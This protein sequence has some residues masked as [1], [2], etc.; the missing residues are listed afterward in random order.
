MKEK[1]NRSNKLKDFKSKFGI[2]CINSNV[3][4]LKLLKNIRSI[5]SSFLVFSLGSFFISFGLK[6]L[7]I[8]A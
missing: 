2:Q 1:I 3:I 6:F 7:K 5:F 8:S 4:S